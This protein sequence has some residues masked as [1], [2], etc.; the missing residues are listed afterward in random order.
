MPRRDL[1]ADPLIF[2]ARHGRWVLVGGLVAGVLLP[3]LAAVLRPFVPQMVALLLFL[4]A[5]RI[6]TGVF[7]GALRALPLTVGVVLAVQ[8]ALPLLVI[9][10][11]RALGLADTPTAIALAIMCAAPSIVGSPNMC[12][13]LG[14]PPELAMRLL[15]LGTALLPVTVIPV[16]WFLP[17]LGAV[18]EVLIAALRLLAVIALAAGAGFALRRFAWRAPGAVALAR[19]DGVSAL[20]LAVFVVGLMPA[21]GG[22]LRGDPWVAA[23][24][25]ATVLV[26]NFGAQILVHRIMRQRGAGVAVPVAL[27]SGNRNIALFLVALPPEVTAPIMVFIG[28]YQIPMFLTP[29]VMGWVYGQGGRQNPATG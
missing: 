12:L 4:A 23:Y 25:M 20:V 5:L 16:F 17:Q 29:L 9:A 6:G 14:A 8:L 1:P 13:M 19:L 27:I 26:V 22:A 15:I 18:S 21:V 10:G 7:A 28:C 24:W 2:A 3:G 11:A